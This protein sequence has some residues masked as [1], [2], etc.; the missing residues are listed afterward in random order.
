LMMFVLVS[1]TF[2]PLVSRS[3]YRDV[4]NHAASYPVA[5]LPLAT[6]LTPSRV[7]EKLSCTV[8]PVASR[9]SSRMSC[10]SMRELPAS[11]RNVPSPRPA[12]GSGGWLGSQPA[13]RP[14]STRAASHNARRVIEHL[15]RAGPASVT[16]VV[17]QVG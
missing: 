12:G 15:L 14:T 8:T 10:R 13:I 6:A 7:P 3:K 17:G 1:T 5:A 4:S 2:A 9:A 11:T 16:P